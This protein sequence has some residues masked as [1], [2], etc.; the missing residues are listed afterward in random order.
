[1]LAEIILPLLSEAYKAA[2]FQSGIKVSSE[3]HKG[4]I[5][6]NYIMM[7]YCSSAYSIIC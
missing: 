7:L 5:L 1:M 4:T 6:T 2:G 3:E